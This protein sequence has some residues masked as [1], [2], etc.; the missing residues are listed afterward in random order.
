MLE[1]F[2]NEL[3]GAELLVRSTLQNIKGELVYPDTDPAPAPITIIKPQPVT[4]EDREYLPDGAHVKDFKR[5]YTMD[6]VPE[7][8]TSSGPFIKTNTGVTYRFQNVQDRR[9]EG[10]AIRIIMR[11]LTDDE[12]SNIKPQEVQ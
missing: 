1:Y 9:L 8:F 4:G 11:R 12:P 2:G 6:D 5:T 3:E 10:G 7:I